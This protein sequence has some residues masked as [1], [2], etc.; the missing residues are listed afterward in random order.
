[1]NWMA[2]IYALITVESS[3]NDTAVGDYGKSIGCLQIQKGVIEDV[4]KIYGTKYTEMDRY[5]RWQSVEMCKFY[6][7]YWGFVYERNTGKEASYEVLARI[8][9]GGPYGYKKESTKVYWEKVKH[10]L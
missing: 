3:G 8:W 2:L 5:Y 10:L 6:L 9:N 1:M 4:N 7:T